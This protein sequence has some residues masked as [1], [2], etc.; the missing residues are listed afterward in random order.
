MKDMGII[1]Y[2]NKKINEFKNT[3]N[4]SWCGDI[5]GEISMKEFIQLNQ[6]KWMKK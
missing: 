5:L 4:I 6:K 3:E 2:L 1:K